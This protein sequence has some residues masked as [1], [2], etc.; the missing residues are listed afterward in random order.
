MYGDHT[1]K[2][3]ESLYGRLPPFQDMDDRRIAAL[4]DAL[5]E[6]LQAERERCAGVAHSYL[7]GE[8]ACA[9][10]TPESRNFVARRVAEQIRAA[11]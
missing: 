7:L 11:D 6:L 10:R 9:D 2:V 8:D 4:E 3:I 5:R 1:L